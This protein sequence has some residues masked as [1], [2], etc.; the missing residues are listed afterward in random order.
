[1]AQATLY[2]VREPQRIEAELQNKLNQDPD[3][4]HAG[5][6]EAMQTKMVDYSS[7][8]KVR[9]SLSIVTNLWEKTCCRRYLEFLDE[10]NN[11]VLLC[12]LRT[13]CG[14][15]TGELT[16]SRLRL[17]TECNIQIN[18]GRR[19]HPMEVMTRIEQV[20]VDLK[21]VNSVKKNKMVKV[22]FNGRTTTWMTNVTIPII[23]ELNP[24][25]TELQLVPPLYD[26]WIYYRYRSQIK[27][28]ILEI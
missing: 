18:C 16:E 27:D 14:S 6:I 28:V 20:F 13:I 17:L 12:E 2:W 10:F 8:V 4:A 3:A 11:Q 24:L 7:F 23:K 21:L 22:I 15:E 26:T 1:M 9:K 19:T 25:R 5:L